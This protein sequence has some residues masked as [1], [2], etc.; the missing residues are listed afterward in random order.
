MHFYVP[1][2]GYK[3]YDIQSATAG[4]ERNIT[5]IYFISPVVYD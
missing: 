3:S 4:F 5:L 2:A 1:G